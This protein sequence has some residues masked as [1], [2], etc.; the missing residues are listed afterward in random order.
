MQFVSFFSPGKGLFVSQG[1]WGEGKRKVRMGGWK[2]KKEEEIQPFFLSSHHPPR[3]YYFLIIAI[4]IEMAS[5]SWTLKTS[6]VRFNVR[7]CAII[8]RRGGLKN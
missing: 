5:G 2:V 4:F 3:A 7:D 8:I 6:F 1:G